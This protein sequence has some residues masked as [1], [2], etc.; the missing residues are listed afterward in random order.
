MGHY[1]SAAEW[2]N[3]ALAFNLNMHWLV[4]RVLMRNFVMGS[5]PPIRIM[6]WHR[7]GEGKGNCST[8]FWDKLSL[9]ACNQIALAL[10][11]GLWRG[12]LHSEWMMGMQ[13]VYSFPALGCI[14]WNIYLTNSPNVLKRVTAKL[15]VKSLSDTLLYWSR[16]NIIR[17]CNIN[18]PR[19]NRQSLEGGVVYFIGPKC[20]RKLRSLSTNKPAFRYV[21]LHY[22]TSSSIYHSCKNVTST[23]WSNK[24]IER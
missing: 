5:L 20:D 21:S 6:S 18:G 16:Q 10:K 15:E 2:Q 23:I 1:A 19:S 8:C 11:G 24:V 3:L 7:L 13:M 14:K 17:N 22:S 4:F 12:I 9:D